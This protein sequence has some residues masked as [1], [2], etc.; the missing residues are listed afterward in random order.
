[1]L[2][3]CGRIIDRQHSSQFLQTLLEKGQ[4]LPQHSPKHPSST[5]PMHIWM[6]LLHTTAFLYFCDDSGMFLGSTT[7][8]QSGIHLETTRNTQNHVKPYASLYSPKRT[9]SERQHTIPHSIFCVQDLCKA[10]PFIAKPR[11]GFGVGLHG[12][13]EPPRNPWYYKVTW[14]IHD[15]TIFTLL[16]VTQETLQGIIGTSFWI[17]FHTFLT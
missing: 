11:E 8:R 16:L 6:H 9:A 14:F 1:M 3:G 4:H 7:S 2:W 10:N 12:I 13:M 17:N 15:T 5:Q